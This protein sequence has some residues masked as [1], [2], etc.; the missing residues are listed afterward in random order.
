MTLWP[1]REASRDP[2]NVRPSDSAG[3]EAS[4]DPHAF[5]VTVDEKARD[6][7][8]VS[9][10]ANNARGSRLSAPAFTLDSLA[11]TC[12]VVQLDSCRLVLEYGIYRL[13]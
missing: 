1:L 13:R 8:L 3:A 11:R 6:A 9:E 7:I 2:T 4:P 5:L 12:R 10:L